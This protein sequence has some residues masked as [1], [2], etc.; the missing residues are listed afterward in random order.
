MAIANKKGEM[1]LDGMRKLFAKLEHNIQCSG[2][3]EVP[4]QPPIFKYT[5]PKLHPVCQQCIG[6]T[7]QAGTNYP[8]KICNANFPVYKC[9]LAENLLLCLPTRCKFTINGCQVMI[10]LEDLLVHEDDCVYRNI[11]CSFLN[12]EDSVIFIGFH[13]HLKIKHES[14]IKLEKATTEDQIVVQAEQQPTAPFVWY[15]QQ[16]TLHRRHFYSE[17]QRNARGVW[18]M[19][20][21]FH[22]TPLDARHYF[23]NIKVKGEGM[24]KISFQGQVRS[25]DEDKETIMLNETALI[26]SE[27]LAKRLS[28]V[29]GKMNFTLSVWSDKDEIKDEDAESGISEESQ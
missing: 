24:D 15:P 19:W 1:D 5:C 8:C 21:Y 16:L 29:E 26:C 11:R 7:Y 17:V 4:R 28:G 20:I 13:D 9:D 22:G 6:L 25:I 23:F 10:M 12:C 3:Q 14:M 27:V 2:C 18:F